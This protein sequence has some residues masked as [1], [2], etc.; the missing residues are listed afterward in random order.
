MLKDTLVR[1][2]MPLLKIRL[3]IKN[4]VIF[5][6]NSI[7]YP[8]SKFDG[9]NRIC[10]NTYISRTH[11]GYGSYIGNN[12][13]IV[14]TEIGKYSCIGP[15]VRTTSGTHPVDFVSMHPAFYSIRGQAGF[16]YVNE[17]KY[18]EGMDRNYHTIIGNDVWIGDSALIVEGVRIGDGAVIAAGA[19]VTKDV[20]PYAIVGG[21][22]AKII[23]YRFDEEQRNTLKKIEWWNKETEWIKSHAK[24]FLNVDT[25]IL[26]NAKERENVDE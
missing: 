13:N 25:F 11:I 8:S 5:E 2:V 1:I 26:E 19:I 6:P 23:R 17:Q 9:Y 20:P 15:Y 12:C 21:I 10:R 3:R 7:V 22:P 14:S 16:T 18:D 24:E 4:H